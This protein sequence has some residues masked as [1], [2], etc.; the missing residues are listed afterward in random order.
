MKMYARTMNCSIYPAPRL[1]SPA[2]PGQ[3]P[4]EF[5][6]RT[7]AQQSLF[8]GR[9]YLVLKWLYEM[10]AVAYEIASDFLKYLRKNRLTVFIFC[11]LSA[12]LLLFMV[13]VLSIHP[14]DLVSNIIAGFISIPV[15][16]FF[17]RFFTFTALRIEKG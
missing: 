2:A 7:E 12:G 13:T 8:K 6:Y 11:L 9:E 15:V 16:Y 10:L 1:S 5:P 17:I 4:L 3:A 14:Q